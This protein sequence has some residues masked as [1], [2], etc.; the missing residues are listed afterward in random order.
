MVLL[1]I[2]DFWVLSAYIL[3]ILSAAACVVY[4]VL[5]WNKGGENE[6]L[7]IEEESKWEAEERRIEV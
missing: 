4:G 1:G 5:N 3:C 2:P 6:A 7:E